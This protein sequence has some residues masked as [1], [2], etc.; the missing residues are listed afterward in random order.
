LIKWSHTLGATAFVHIELSRDG[1]ESWETIAASVQNSGASVGTFNW[2]VT[3]PPVTAAARVRVTWVNGSAVSDT[4][5]VD[6][7]VS[8]AYVL[9]D[10]AG[11]VRTLGFGTSRQQKWTSNLGPSDKVNVLLSEDGGAT[12]PHVLAPNVTAT[13]KAN[14]TVPALAGGTANGRVRV[15]WTTNP[16]VHGTT[17]VEL[18]IQ[19][20]FIKV[21]S[22]NVSIDVWSAGASATV[23]WASNLGSTEKVTLELSLD[24]GATYPIVLAANTPADGS[25]TVNVQPGWVTGTAR[26]RVT[27]GENGAVTDVSSQS[28][29]IQ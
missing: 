14:Y 3:G 16:A 28:F 8:D 21:T 5:N 2:V 17:P 13:S 15:V 20:A 12:F 29:V 1:R 7:S 11:L 19:P 23:S 9:L 25:H 4:S 24:G 6:F 26:V 27:W 18:S 10:T 22:P